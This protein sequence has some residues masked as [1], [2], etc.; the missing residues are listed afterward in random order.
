VVVLDHGA[1]RQTKFGELLWQ[2]FRRLWR[3]G[4]AGWTSTDDEAKLVAEIL[5]ALIADP[6]ATAGLRDPTLHE[7]AL[8]KFRHAELAVVVIPFGTLGH[9]F[10][11]VE[12]SIEKVSLL[13]GS[14]PIV[15]I[16]HD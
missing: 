6:P 14:P 12:N 2:G 15:C 16:C 8:E 9:I 11:E 4:E 1:T 7:L 10:L 3:I 13:P 5:E